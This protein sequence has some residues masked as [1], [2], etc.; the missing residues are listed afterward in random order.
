MRLAGVSN[1]GLGTAPLAGLFRETSEAVA[2]GAIERAWELGIRYFDTAPLY[3]SGLAEARLGAALAGRSRDQYSVSTKVG[4]LLRAGA[5]NRDFPG[6]GR[7]GPVFD[8]SRDG[9]R[10]SL[11]ESLDRLRLDHVDAI[12]VHD[13]DDHLD[14]ALDSIDALSGLAA[15][16]GVGT[17]TVE[18]ALE[19]VRRGAVDRVLIA[20][21]YTL[22]DRSAGQVLLPLCAERGISVTAAGVFN[23]G[24]LAGGNT[25]DYRA[26]P[27]RVAA[28]AAELA[29]A[30]RRYQVPLAAVALQFTMRHPAVSRVLVGARSA[31]EVTQDL[32][33]LGHP[34]PDS[35]WSDPLF[36]PPAG[37]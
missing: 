21:R 10:R 11:D 2:R 17:N 36:R 5:L 6:A 16:I 7:L 32:G 26:A 1:V 4:R 24:L 29:A 15:G 34:V 13:P 28:R 30:C 37:S 8:F 3:G 35:L 31:A 27:P 12:F 25:Y 18:T 33:W 14:Q 20:G 22:L 19:F 9:L 23:S